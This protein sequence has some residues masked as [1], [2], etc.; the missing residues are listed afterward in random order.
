MMEVAK[1]CAT[2]RRRAGDFHFVELD[3]GVGTISFRHRICGRREGRAAGGE[4]MKS[5][6]SRPQGRKPRS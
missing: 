2:I 6:T 5:Y 3:R 4:C 1:I